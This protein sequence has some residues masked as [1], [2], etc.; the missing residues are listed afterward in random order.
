[1]F[2]LTHF[3]P[4][5]CFA[6]LFS[7]N[8]QLCVSKIQFNLVSTEFLFTLMQTWVSRTCTFLFVIFQVFRFLKEEKQKKKNP[9]KKE[10]KSI[11]ASKRFNQFR[12]KINLRVINL[13]LN[14]DDDFIYALMRENSIVITQS[15]DSKNENSKMHLI[16]V[17]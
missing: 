15:W 14:F 16:P 3:S 10:R 7:Y 8:S 6:L 13:I 12:I 11:Y 4:V 9:R 1:M 2:F 17:E 5:F